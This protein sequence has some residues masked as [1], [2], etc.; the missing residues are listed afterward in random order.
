[1]V[2]AYEPIWA[3]GKSAAQAITATELT[4]MILYI[5]KILSHYLAGKGNLTMRILYGGSVEPANASELAGG[6]GIDGF[7]IG[8]ASTTAAQFSGIVKA[9]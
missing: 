4:E 2:L 9:L 1:M 5:R 8:H 6:T 7:L 3:I